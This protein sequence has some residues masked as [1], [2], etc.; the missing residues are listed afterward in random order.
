VQQIL[1]DLSFQS[2]AFSKLF[3]RY[4]R[5][6][7]GRSFTA[8]KRMMNS[9]RPSGTVES[10]PQITFV[11]IDSVL[12]QKIQILILKAQCL[13]MLALFLNVSDDRIK[14][15]IVDGEGPVAFLP[16]EVAQSREGLVNPF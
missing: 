6:T 12:L 15:G 11:V 7:V 10:S 13:M 16:G 5:L 2:G 4:G 1:F 9:I 3:A 8:C 14:N